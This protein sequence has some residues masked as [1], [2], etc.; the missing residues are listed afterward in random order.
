VRVTAKKGFAKAQYNLGVMYAN[1]R[2]VPQNNV[3]A[4][5]W[6]NLAAANGREDGDGHCQGKIYYLACVPNRHSIAIDIP[7]FSGSPKPV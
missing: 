2:G 3:Y 4:L 5:M 1:G 6:V 7:H